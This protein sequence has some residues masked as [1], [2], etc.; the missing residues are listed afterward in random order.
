MPVTQDESDAEVETDRYHDG[1]AVVQRLESAGEE[2]ADEEVERHENLHILQE[3]DV[4]V[5]RENFRQDEDDEELQQ[6]AEAV[7]A[8]PGEIAHN[9]AEL[10]REESA[11]WSPT[12]LFILL[13]RAYSRG[14]EQMLLNGELPTRVV[15]M[16]D[17]HD[18]RR[19][20]REL[21]GQALAVLHQDN[22]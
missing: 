11:F 5:V 20:L 17:P 7:D 10:H 21:V 1:S 15:P 19:Q 4:E 8:L 14:N 12:S 6:E 16:M 18:R 2:K 13:S 3:H 9:T 22:R